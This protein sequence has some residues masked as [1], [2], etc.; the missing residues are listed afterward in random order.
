MLTKADP[1]P[2]LTPPAHTPESC[3]ELFDQNLQSVNAAAQKHNGAMTRSFTKL[4][5]LL[6]PPVPAKKITVKVLVKNIETN[7]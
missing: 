3:A 4:P 5:A 1:N 6:P 2:N 7:D